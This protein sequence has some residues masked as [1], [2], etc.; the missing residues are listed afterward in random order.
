[1]AKVIGIPNNDH[2]ITLRADIP[3]DFPGELKLV[4]GLGLWPFCGKEKL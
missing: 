1:M 2:A 3:D 4:K